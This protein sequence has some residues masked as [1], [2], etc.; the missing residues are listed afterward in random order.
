MSAAGARRRYDWGD[1]RPK[2]RHGGVGV[3]GQR[4]AR[5]TGLSGHKVEP[6][7]NGEEADFTIGAREM[8]QVRCGQPGAGGREIGSTHSDN[9]SQR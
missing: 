1:G 5:V 9:P 6:C 8:D 7:H 3:F 4:S 2:T